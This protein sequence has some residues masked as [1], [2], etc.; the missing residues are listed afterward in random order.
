MYSKHSG[1]ALNFII[2][3]GF[4]GGREWQEG[5]WTIQSIGEENL[6]N[7]WVLSNS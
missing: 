5:Y 2:V 4:F 6:T 7:S 3:E 1:Y